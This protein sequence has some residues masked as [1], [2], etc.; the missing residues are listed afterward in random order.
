MTTE[1]NQPSRGV[2]LALAF[3]SG[4]GFVIMMLAFAAGVIGA[5]DE[6]SFGLWLLFG[7]ILFV[8][9][10]GGWFGVVQPHKHFDDINVPMYHGHHEEDE[11]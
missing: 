9:G 8:G 6:N 4:I 2:I 10:I 7:F 1:S 5:M 3:T 11:H